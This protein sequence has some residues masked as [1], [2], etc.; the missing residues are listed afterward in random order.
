MGG[1]SDSV[2]GGGV[3]A[4][5]RAVDEGEVHALDGA[6]HRRHSGAR[7]GD[8]QQRAARRGA[9]GHHEGQVARGARE[10]EGEH[11]AG[12][13]HGGHLGGLA[14][15]E[16]LQQLLRGDDR[17][18]VTLGGR[19]DGGRAGGAGRWLR[20]DVHVGVEGAVVARGPQRV[21]QQRVDV[22]RVGLAGLVRHLR[23][24]LVD[25]Q[26]SA[27]QVREAHGQAG[28]SEHTRAVLH[29]VVG[30]VIVV[31]VQADAVQ[32]RHLGLGGPVA[33]RDAVRA[34]GD[35][36][37]DSGEGGREAGEL[38]GE[39]VRVQRVG[40]VVRAAGVDVQGVLEALGHVGVG[41]GGAQAAHVVVDGASDALPV[42]HAASGGA[43]R[44]VLVPALGG[45]ATRVS[46][47]RHHHDGLLGAGEV[48]EARQ[49]RGARLVQHVGEQA[50]LLVRLGN[51][52]L[53]QVHPV[54]LRV[55]GRVAVEHVVGARARANG[56][57]VP[58]LSLPGRVSLPRVDDG[59]RQVI[60]EGGGGAAAHGAL[61]DG[62]E[63]RRG[64]GIRVERGDGA[65]A[66]DDGALVREPVV[67]HRLRGDARAR[68]LGVVDQ[69][70]AIGLRALRGIEPEQRLEVRRGPQGDEAAASGDPVGD[71]RHLGRA[72]RLL[73]EHQHFVVIKG[74]GD[75]QVAGVGGGEGGDA[76]GLQDFAKVVGEGVAGSSGH[77]HGARAVDARTGRRSVGLEDD[78]HPVVGVLVAAVGERG[79]GGIGEDAVA[80]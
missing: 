54:R 46:V 17:H 71:E 68:G 16:P 59:L 56:G 70:V 38:W 10:V 36:R 22:Q 64:G 72:Q 18:A 3:G 52:D 23:G 26:R 73:A 19:D 4:G 29:P 66:G 45:G 13:G 33:E 78:V 35:G 69:D 37:G 39:E 28:A 50:L 27:V 30:P 57:A 25:V 80:A 32:A 62:G 7:A 24:E 34:V 67:L 79:G 5:Q 15:I 61:A 41:L 51:L 47:A 60:H 76:L 6:R 65:R 49:R 74:D 58:V 8:G 12:E 75:A 2:V 42:V 14:G 43:V 63:R 77:Q 1:A 9:G 55:E 20:V 48:P 31:G 44:E 40:R 53:G 11:R 21:V